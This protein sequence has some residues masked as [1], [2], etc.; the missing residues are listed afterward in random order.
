MII[1]RIGT[2]CA[3]PIVGTIHK[4]N[5]MLAEMSLPLR[6]LTQKGLRVMKILLI[7]DDFACIKGIQNFLRPAGFK[8]VLFKNPC[9]ALKAFKNVH[10]DLVITDFLMP[11]MNGID[12][13][14]EIRK[15]RADTRVIIL[16][17]YA[18]I[19]N[20]I[21]AV[22]NGAYAFFRKPLDPKEL[23]ETIKKIEEEIE[24]KKEIEV[25][26]NQ[27]SIEYVKLSQAA[28]SMKNIIEQLAPI[29]QG[30]KD[31]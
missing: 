23:I 26:L 27:L 28:E 25:N 16:T 19:N 15:M 30:K 8:C 21:S 4:G 22:N 3:P 14:K 7:D 6:N 17:G 9:K 1:T 13:L 11:E 29:N 31:E 18:E 24:N 2:N 20:A 5:F 12:V 10:F